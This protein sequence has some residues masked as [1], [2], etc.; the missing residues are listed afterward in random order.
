MARRAALLSVRPFTMSKSPVWAFMLHPS[1]IT[2]RV[3][4][5]TYHP[6]ARGITGQEAKVP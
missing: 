6:T 4:G 2:R 5:T 1:Y 3:A